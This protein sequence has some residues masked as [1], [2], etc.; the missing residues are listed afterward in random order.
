MLDHEQETKSVDIHVLQV[1][2]L[3]GQ[4]LTEKICFL[5]FTMKTGACH[6]VYLLQYST[7]RGDSSN[8]IRRFNTGTF[9]LFAVA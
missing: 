3:P 4:F 6:T 9:V 2:R 1:T 8:M 7:Y 5:L